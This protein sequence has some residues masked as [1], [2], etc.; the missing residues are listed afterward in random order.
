M[1]DC[2]MRAILAVRE[3]ESRSQVST[4]TLMRLFCILA[5]LTVLVASGQTGP[6]RPRIERFDVPSVTLPSI[7]AAYNRTIAGQAAA[8]LNKECP[9]SP[10]SLC[11][12]GWFKPPF[13]PLLAPGDLRGDSGWKHPERVRDLVDPKNYV[14]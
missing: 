7:T 14:S 3:H 10:K 4:A 13:P 11:A 1:Q 6:H 8:N 9:Y 12:D 2:S 5:A